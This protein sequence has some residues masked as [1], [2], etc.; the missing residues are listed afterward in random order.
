MP[1]EN[2][3]SIR[4]DDETRKRLQALAKSLN[5]TPSELLRQSIDVMTGSS[6]ARLREV[7]ESYTALKDALEAGS[8]LVNVT[9][10]QVNHLRGEYVRLKGQA[11]AA[12]VAVEQQKSKKR[13]GKVEPIFIPAEYEKPSRK[14]SK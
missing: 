1:K 2:V 9:T 5:P 6:E 13:T 7:Q 8:H 3:L 11:M 12:S 14:E 10:E 4:V